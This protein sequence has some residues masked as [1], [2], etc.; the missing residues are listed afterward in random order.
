MRNMKLDKNYIIG[1]IDGEGTINI[2][3]YPDGRIR[4]QLLVFN[5]DREI[6]ES[7]KETLELDSPILRVVRVKDVI[8]RRKPCFRLQ[9]RSKKDIQKVVNLFEEFKPVVK[10]KEYEKFKKAYDHWV[11]VP[12]CS[13][14]S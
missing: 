12:V 14:G 2:T 5:T 7:I 13:L 8:K 4:P 6:L 9:V 3:K 11:L 10:S 1:F